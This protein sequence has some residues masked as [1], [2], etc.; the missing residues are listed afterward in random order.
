[1]EI[2]QVLALWRRASVPA[3]QRAGEALRQFSGLDFAVTESDVAAVSWESMAARLR[4]SMPHQTLYVVHLEGVGLF[5]AHVLMIFSDANGQRLA[6]A[7]MG[8][9]VK[10]PLDDMGL[11]ALAEVGN[12]VGTAFLNVFSDLFRAVWEPTIPQVLLTSAE[13]ITQAIQPGSNVLISQALFQVT[14]AE[15]SAQIVVVPDLSRD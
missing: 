3:L 1:M 5:Q 2:Q 9:P 14:D 7:L 11:S 8:E 4:Q 13:D 15:I 12:V 10:T 6:S